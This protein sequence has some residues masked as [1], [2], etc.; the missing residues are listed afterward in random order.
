MFGL[1]DHPALPAPALAGPIGELLEHPCG[2]LDRFVALSGVLKFG[3]EG[4]QQT[5]IFGQT[6][7]KIHAIRFAPRHQ[8]VAGKAAVGPQHD[9]HL[10][11]AGPNLPD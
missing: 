5:S 10:R 2:L 7:E 11:P 8:G 1:A 9:V 6:E 3:F 4:G